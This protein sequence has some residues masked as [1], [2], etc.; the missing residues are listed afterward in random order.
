MSIGQNAYDRP[1]YNMQI[2][3]MSLVMLLVIFFDIINNFI[4]YRKYQSLGD[5][6][7]LVNW[8]VLNDQIT[9]LH[10]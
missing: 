9:M 5:L 8:Y 4:L 1:L 6:H 2:F 3:L 7:I 10:Y